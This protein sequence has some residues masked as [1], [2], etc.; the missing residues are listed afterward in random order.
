MNMNRRDFIKGAA[1]FGGLGCLFAGGC[2][3]P[4]FAGDVPQ[5]RFGV[6]SDVHIRAG[7]GGIGT[8]EGYGTETL[9]KAF[10]YFRDCGADAVV[11]AGDIADR[12]LVRE[13]KAVAD[14]WQRV[15]PGDMAPDGR[16]V[17]RIFVYGNHDAS[18]MT[19]GRRVFDDTAVLRREAK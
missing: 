6:V 10:A 13:L 5:L 4:G 17:E 9:E 8:A 12:G 7:A 19:Y 15:F 3:F 16:K 11:I 14:A 1:G 18:G 2:S